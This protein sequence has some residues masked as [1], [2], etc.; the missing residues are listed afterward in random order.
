MNIYEKISEQD[1]LLIRTMYQEGNTA[2]QIQIKFPNICENSII[3]IVRDGGIEVRKAQRY[4]KIK[5]EDFFENIDSSVK[6]YILGLIITDGYI[7]YPKREGRSPSW[8]VTLQE[9]DL[10]ILEEIKNILELDK[11]ITTRIH[12]G[13]KEFYLIVTSKKMVKDLEKYGVVPRKSKSIRLPHIEDKYM[14]DLIRGIFD[15]D[16]CIAK[17]GVC[18]FCGNEKFVLDI[19]N[20]LIEN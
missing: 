5:D 6:A 11:K 18:S 13:K 19:K 8:G 17:N 10:H 7:T 4:S 9:S 14:P 1:V 15:G 2:K 16:G 12:N 3:K 20:F